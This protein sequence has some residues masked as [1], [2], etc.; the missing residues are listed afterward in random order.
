MRAYRSCSGSM[1]KRGKRDYLFQECP[2]KRPRRRHSHHR[3]RRSLGP[4]Q[5]CRSDRGNRP[6]PTH[7]SQARR[8]AARRGR[9]VDKGHREL[10]R[11]IG[12]R[13]A[14][15]S[16]KRSEKGQCSQTQCRRT[17]LLR[18]QS[19]PLRRYPLRR[20]R[21]KLPCR[22]HAR[23][24]THPSYRF[25]A[26]GRQ[27]QP[28]TPPIDRARRVTF[29][30]AGIRNWLHRPASIDATAMVEVPPRLRK[31]RLSVLLP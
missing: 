17:I 20:V 1:N 12:G 19:P 13:G 16:L 11:L 18:T 31:P 14:Q 10:A 28:S 27:T 21:P 30:I 15:L 2:G 26:R 8:F 23:I 9:S 6:V 3:R 25:C 5:Y 24:N 22:R 4:L 29:S 7:R